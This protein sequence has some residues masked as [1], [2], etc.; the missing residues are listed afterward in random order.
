MAF[1]A[2]ALKR[3]RMDDLAAF[4]TNRTQRQELAARFDANFLQKF[5]P[6]CFQQAVVLVHFAF[7]DRPMSVVLLFEK[8]PARMGE[9]HFD[10]TIPHS[11]HEQPC[12]GP[13]LH[14]LNLTRH[15]RNAKS[16]SSKSLPR[17]KIHSQCRRRNSTTS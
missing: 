2:V 6:G 9:K 8:R 4:L 16:K 12:A 17:S 11:I 15:R 1:L 3:P 14:A 13:I 7:G 5:A 10:L